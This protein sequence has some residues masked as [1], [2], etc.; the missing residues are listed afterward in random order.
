MRPILIEKIKNIKGL[1]GIECFN[2]STPLDL[3][4]KAYND[5]IFRGAAMF[6]G[7]DCHIE[8]KVGKYATRFPDGI[9]NID[10]FIKAVKLKQTT[11]VMHNGNE[12]I[13]IER[14]LKK[15]I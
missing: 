4:L 10:D 5:A 1:H 9:N 2:G 6:G 3:N 14:Y 13:D 7:S 15:V 8:S 12:Y 11:P